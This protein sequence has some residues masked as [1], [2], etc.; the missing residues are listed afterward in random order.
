MNAFILLLINIKRRKTDA[1]VAYIFVIFGIGPAGHHV[2]ADADS[3]IDFV[4]GLFYLLKGS[5]S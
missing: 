1:V 5:P 2:W 3:R 4:Y